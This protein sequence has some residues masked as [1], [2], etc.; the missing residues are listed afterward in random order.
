MS[1]DV[2]I[3]GDDTVAAIAAVDAVIRMAT[4]ADVILELDLMERARHGSAA[5]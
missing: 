4:P 5:T 3:V 2:R 1:S